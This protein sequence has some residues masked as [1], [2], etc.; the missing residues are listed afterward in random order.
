MSQVC[1]FC[2]TTTDLNT[3]LAIALDNGTKVNVAICD[4]H[5]EDATV[6]SA[7]QAYL[8]KQKKLEEIIAQ[9]KALGF[10]LVPN[11]GGLTV[12]E[13][14]SGTPAPKAAP[15]PKAPAASEQ[16][17]TSDLVPA[18]LIDRK[19]SVTSVGGSVGGIAIQSLPSYDRE[20]LQSKLPE[21]ALKGH[22]QIA[23]TEGRE[24][25]PLAFQAQRMDG[26]GTTRIRIKKTMDDRRL[27]QHFKKMADQSMADRPPNFA[28]EGY[29]NTITVCPI[30]HGEKT[31]NGKTCPKCD[32]TGDITTV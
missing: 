2:D 31:V 4:K 14:I 20:S 12:A 32:G 15:A 19:G 8:N 10:N 3:T 7:R 6:K 1:V 16:L 27:Q 9:A 21:D 25:V 18:E 28:R 23:V 11:A 30:C 5:A 17:D 29:R 22:V 13:P 24:G 26:T